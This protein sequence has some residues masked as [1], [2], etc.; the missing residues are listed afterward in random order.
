MK[1]GKR[2][3]SLGRRAFEANVYVDE[4]GLRFDDSGIWADDQN[5]L[6]QLVM[7][8]GDLVETTPGMFAA[9]DRWELIDFNDRGEV[10]IRGVVDNFIGVYVATPN[11]IPEPAG[12]VLAMAAIG[13]VV[14][15]A[16][17]RNAGLKMKATTSR[18]TPDAT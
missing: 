7:R 4:N 1:E 16:I 2:P 12:V 14:L 10:L 11:P 18:R 6:L 15:A 5:G 8:D 9:L 13:M 3:P 17:G